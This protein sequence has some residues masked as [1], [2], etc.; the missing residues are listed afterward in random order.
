MT[1]RA[2]LIKE[3]AYSLWETEGSPDGRHEDHWAQAERE[4]DRANTGSYATDTPRPPEMDLEPIP[5]SDQ[6][7]SGEGKAVP[8]ARTGQTANIKGPVEG[9]GP[10]NPVHHT[11]Q[12]PLDPLTK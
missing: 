12:Q 8:P 1:D 9:A 3:R 4:I 10:D 11:G 6:V 5:M 2:S 7:G